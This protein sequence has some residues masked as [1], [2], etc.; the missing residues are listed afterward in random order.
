MA[1]Y[2]P[3]A[4]THLVAE[5]SPVRLGAILPQNKQIVYFAR[6]HLVPNQLHMWNPGAARQ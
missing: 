3:N 2:D 4:I 1:F 6:L 5:P